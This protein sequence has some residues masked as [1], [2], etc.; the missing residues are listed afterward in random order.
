MLS[1]GAI[2]AGEYGIPAIANLQNATKI[3]SDGDQLFV[4]GY[5]GKVIVLLNSG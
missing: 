4:D 1:H 3:L 5:S 2:V